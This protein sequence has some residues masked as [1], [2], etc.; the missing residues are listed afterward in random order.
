[1]VVKSLIENLVDSLVPDLMTI[2]GTADELACL[3]DHTLLR[4]EAIL[5]EIEKH[6]AEGWNTGFTRSVSMAPASLV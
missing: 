5:D 1:M 2:P 3:I 6:C 4:P